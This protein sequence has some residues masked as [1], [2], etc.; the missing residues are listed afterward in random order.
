[1][2]EGQPALPLCNT[3]YSASNLMDQNESHP[4]D[5]DPD[6]FVI[7]LLFAIITLIALPGTFFDL[8]V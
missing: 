7:A 4:I 6:H 8:P 3:G 5:A 1:M 2:Q